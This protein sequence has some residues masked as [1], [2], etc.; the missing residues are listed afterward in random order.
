MRSR[1]IAGFVLFAGALAAVI[2]LQTRGAGDRTRAQFSY[3]VQDGRANAAVNLRL[4]RSG[5]VLELFRGRALVGRRPLVATSGIVV[6][7][8]RATRDTLTIDFSGGTFPVP[9]GIRFDGGRGGF[10]TLRVEARRPRG[11]AVYRMT[12]PGSGTISMRNLRIA[13]SNLEPLANIGA[14][15]HAIFELPSGATTATF[16]DDGTPG[17]GV[18][19]LSGTGFETTD[20]SGAARVTVYLGVGSETFDFQ[21]FD[22]TDPDGAGPQ[23]GLGTVEVSGSDQAGSDLSDDVF[24]IGSNITPVTSVTTAFRGGAGNDTFTLGAAGSTLSPYFGRITISGDAQAANPA[25]TRSVT[26]TQT[27]SNTRVTGDTLLLDDAGATGGHSYTFNADPS[28]IVRDGAQGFG[29]EG[30]ETL[31]LNA[32]A[33]G[34]NSYVVNGYAYPLANLTIT[35]GSATDVLSATNYVYTT[36]GSATYVNANL[37]FNGAG[38]ADDVMLEALPTSVSTINGGGD[39][40]TLRVTRA[41]ANAGT[42]LNGE[43]GSDQ[44]RLV[45]SDAGSQTV[46][47]GGPDP[48]T[49]IVDPGQGGSYC[50]DSPTSVRLRELTAKRQGRS[51][52]VSWRTASEVGVDGFHVFRERRSRT[53][54]VN[55]TLIPARA[56]A[57]G[58]TYRFRDAAAPLGSLRYRIQTV[59]A[60][61]R[62]AW[63]G[64]VVVR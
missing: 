24:T 30:V 34:A 61:G 29:I 7:G 25:T 47:T 43:A 56:V 23:S 26:C 52:V 5:H 10:D 54:R 41:R 62:R 20:I 12:G 1:W 28:A 53:V 63:I 37:I 33:A 2:L 42:A 49:V 59:G 22:T 51:V 45:A 40:D 9:G 16:G 44:L 15:N 32:A 27:I 35:G 8:G 18:N 50:S 6:R 39:N 60:D 46:L 13:F 11:D 21:G 3:A 55:R 17:N 14:A 57:T 36:P 38:G 48:D 31:T 58:A 4:R 19:R 64:S